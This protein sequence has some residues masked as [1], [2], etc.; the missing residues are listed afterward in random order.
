M[1]VYLE[2]PVCLVSA[3]SGACCQ[4]ETGL[5]AVG[6][7]SGEMGCESSLCASRWVSEWR[8]LTGTSVSKDERVVKRGEGLFN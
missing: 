3:L 1:H 4:E 7:V 5:F 6:M 2:L 8:L